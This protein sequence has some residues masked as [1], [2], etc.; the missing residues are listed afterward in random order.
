MN[1]GI[2]TDTYYPQVSGVA[3][4]I[5]TLR[6]QLERQGHNVY[7]FTT[8]DPGVDKNVFERNIFRFTSI[9]FVSFTDRRIAIK[10][11]HRA[12]KIAQALKLDIIHTQT[13]FSL[14]IMG[15]FVARKMRIPCVHT[16]HTMYEDYL[17]YVAKGKL[18]KPVHV[19]QISRSFLQNMSGIIAPSERV[20]NTLLSYGV[21]EPITVIPTGVDLVKFRKKDHTNYRKR[22]G[23]SKDTPLLL[24][25]SRLAYEKNID[26]LIDA[27][28]KIKEKI[29]AAYLMICGDG[30]AREDLE[31]QVK[32]LHLTD[33]VIFTGEIDND[34]V[35]HYYHM[36]NI[37]VST[38]VSES[39]GLT[40]NEA[41]ASGLKVITTHSPYTDELLDEECLG[42]TFSS[43]DEFVDDVIEYLKHPD[44]YQNEKV[45]E[46]KLM[47]TSAELFGKK[48]VDFYKECIVN[49]NQD[50]DVQ[51]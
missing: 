49:Y 9:P 21:T 41:L 4:S 16:Y 22:Y 47:A 34:Q 28:V 33:S 1:I 8:T 32:K 7:I 29:S 23:L 30:P 51:D 27:F 20:L 3:T 31:D 39:Q 12:L 11:V 17:H 50:N 26:Q 2:F 36:A 14:G 24:T 25:L 48:V 37:F 18:L 44:L 5:K 43:L 6:N 45:L 19:K 35:A 15:K 42:K 38:S 10:G 46:Q 13:E 40:Y